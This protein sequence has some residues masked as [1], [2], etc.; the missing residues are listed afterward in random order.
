MNVLIF[1][2][3][4]LVLAASLAVSCDGEP[5]TSP[6]GAEP[7]VP[8]T[9]TV[10]PAVAD[11]PALGTTV[12]LTAEV[13]DQNGA[14]MDGV[15]ITWASSDASVATADAS[16]L[17]TAAGN[18]MAMI[19]ATAGSASGSAVVTVTQSVTSVE[20]SPSATA[21][22]ALGETVQ[23][24]A[25][26]FDANRQVVGGAEVSW[27][28]SDSAV[29]AVDA[30]GLVTAVGN[31]E[32]TITAN[33]EASSGSAEITVMEDLVPAS[34]VI[35]TLLDRQS[36][37]YFLCSRVVCRNGGSA[38]RYNYL[39]AGDTIRVENFQDIGA[40]VYDQ[41]GHKMVQDLDVEWHITDSIQ[42]ESSIGSMV[43]MRPYNRGWSEQPRRFPGCLCHVVRFN[44]GGSH[45]RDPV[46]TSLVAS[47]QVSDSLTL[48]DT[49]TVLVPARMSFAAMIGD[50]GAPFHVEAGGSIDFDMTGLFVS[51]RGLPVTYEVRAGK[52][53]RGSPP[54]AD[55]I[56]RLEARD[57]VI[58]VHGLA[59]GVARL[60][61]R[62]RTEHEYFHF[63][64]PHG[65]Y[66]GSTP[67]P[68]VGVQRAP[69]SRFRIELSYADDL[70]PCVRSTID[71]A[72]G[73]WEKALTDNELA[74]SEPCG[75][76]ANALE[77]SVETIFQGLGGPIGGALASCIDSLPR[78]GTILLSE[79]AFLGWNRDPRFHSPAINLMYQVVRHEIGHV[80]GLVGLQDTLVEGDHFIG[81]RAV[82]EF[83]R[84]GGMAEGVPMEKN[85]RAHWSNDEL[86]GELMRPSIGLTELPSVSAITLGALVDI[87][88]TVDMSAAEAYEVGQPQ[89]YSEGEG[90]VV[91]D[92]LDRQ[93]KDA[94][95][96]NAAAC[97]FTNSLCGLDGV[98][99]LPVGLGPARTGRR[100]RMPKPSRLT[101][102]SS[103]R[104]S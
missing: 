9:V 66:V 101:T 44:N 84:L 26:A 22:T 77:I 46:W 47:L 53:Q 64:T 60:G 41:Y 28:S 65:V 21:L 58:S 100:C 20:V 74:E 99:G 78:A 76:D 45:P 6:G 52:E 73:W 50:W 15:A 32:A 70:S 39:P 91:F 94:V 38:T 1:R 54:M 29:A 97:N 24:V 71:G 7:R 88:W 63:V 25:E 10:T 30:S 36:E 86:R 33:V 56:L 95:P 98:F 61:I 16:G 12:Q 17:V 68:A 59:D 48:A 69:S 104:P 34:L 23:L 42:Y 11:L 31:G 79:Q 2:R 55:T 40:T 5:P 93:P 14:M 102:R 43:T 92:G 4:T 49:A 83:R 103:W 72:V 67:C 19:T 27:T 85:D 57:N 87:G 81:D 35:E 18:G 62:V 96:Q 82:A 80:L 8:T 51:P 13:H 90:L 3:S 37:P 89:L 75:V